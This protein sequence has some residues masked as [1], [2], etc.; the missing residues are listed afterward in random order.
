MTGDEGAHARPILVLRE[1]V[2]NVLAIS[3]VLP[4]FDDIG[5]LGYPPR[6]VVYPVVPP[7]ITAFRFLLE[8]RE[9]ELKPTTLPSLLLFRVFLSFLFFP[10]PSSKIEELENHDM[11]C[12]LLS[13]VLHLVHV[14]LGSWEM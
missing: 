4:A 7:W 13:W 10:P 11:I 3:L 14:S 1:C 5:C 8:N 2:W 6:P 12:L 9:T